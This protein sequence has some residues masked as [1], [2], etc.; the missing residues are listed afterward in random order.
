LTEIL[1]STKS[2]FMLV[3]NQIKSKSK[4]MTQSE[5]KVQVILM[6]VKWLS[7]A[8]R[9]GSEVLAITIDTGTVWDSCSAAPAVIEALVTRV[10][11]E[12]WDDTKTRI[13]AWDSARQKPT[14]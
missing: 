9:Y 4:S 7:P 5:R 12:N 3:R 14:R 6:T 10:A 11:E 8:N 2:E 13:V 1:F